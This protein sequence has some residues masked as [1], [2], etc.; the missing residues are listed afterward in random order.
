MKY[1]FSS[2]A[3]VIG[4]AAAAAVD[5]NAAD[6]D[7]GVSPLGISLTP[8]ANTVVKVTVS[9]KGDKGYNIL[10]RGTILDNIPVNKLRVSKGCEYIPCL[11][12]FCNMF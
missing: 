9:N 10:H 8:V 4:I 1:S 7:Q 2:L 6:I 3:A 11:D 5:L 12:C